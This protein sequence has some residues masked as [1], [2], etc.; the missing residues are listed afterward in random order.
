MHYINDKDGLKLLGMGQAAVIAVKTGGVDVHQVRINHPDFGDTP[1]IPYIQT[2]GILK[3]PAIGDIV[4]VFCNEGFHSYPMVWGTKLHDSAVKALLGSARN[5]ATVIYSTGADNKTISHTII[6][7]DGPDRGIRIKTQG[8]NKIEMKNTDDVI[9][10][11]INGNTVTMN[12]AGI[13]LKRGGSTITMTPDSITIKSPTITLESSA[14]KAVMNAT[15]NVR[16]GDDKATVD[17]VIISTHDQ[18]S[19]NAG[20]QTTN[21]PTKL[22]ASI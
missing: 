19:G 2:A 10:T 8:G 14:S 16:A 21:G 6:L 3:V 9:I 17:K 11:Q 13:E 15:V 1:F 4:Y 7:D 18:V 12:S 5:N 22:G 20:Y